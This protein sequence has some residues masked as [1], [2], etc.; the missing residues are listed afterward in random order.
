MVRRAV[1]ALL[2]LTLALVW[3]GGFAG[4]ISTWHVA[5]G[6]RAL[7]R[8]LKGV[9]TEQ[10]AERALTE[11]G[12]ALD[13]NPLSRYARLQY[14]AASDAA[15]ARLGNART[16][17]LAPKTTLSRAVLA[18]ALE[19]HGDPAGATL[20]RIGIEATRPEE[21]EILPA[22]ALRQLAVDSA[23]TERCP[24]ALPLLEV[25]FPRAPDDAGLALG[26]AACLNKRGEGSQ[27]LPILARI[28]QRDPT[29][30]WVHFL[31][32]EAFLKVGDF[33]Q[34]EQATRWL[35]VR[36]PQFYLG[37]RLHGDV[38]AASGRSDDAL[39]SYRAALALEPQSTWLKWR[40][41]EIERGSHVPSESRQRD[42]RDA[43][44]SRG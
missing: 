12:Q 43:S 18:G 40:I 32:G 9:G 14:Q 2:L 25:A 41:G 35:T 37:W 33:A 21:I 38:L 15:V 4:W 44:Q 36:S 7:H 17:L 3:S 27:S 24:Q 6:R 28:Y 11:I 16:A 1:V 10:D 39:E 23:V 31:L 42:D 19:R 5:Q 8:V 20:I 29:S 34:A 13:A 22:A 26:Y 30:K